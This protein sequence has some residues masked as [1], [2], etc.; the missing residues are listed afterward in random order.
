MF[1]LVQQARR[2]G[3]TLVPRL[4]VTAIRSSTAAVI[5][6]STT[7]TVAN[8]IATDGFQQPA[9]RQLS[10]ANLLFKDGDQ[11]RPER[12]RNRND[13]LLKDN[14][15]YFDKVKKKKLGLLGK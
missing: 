15:P 10:T 11:K 3:A 13:A 6:V 5:S 4:S 2:H 14:K 12:N 1:S 8:R 9:V 7:T